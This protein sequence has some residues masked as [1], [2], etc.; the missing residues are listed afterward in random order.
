MSVRRIEHRKRNID[1]IAKII[2]FILVQLAKASHSVSLFFP[3]LVSVFISELVQVKSIAKL[4]KD[5]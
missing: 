1:L 3:F 4:V 5:Q 2:I